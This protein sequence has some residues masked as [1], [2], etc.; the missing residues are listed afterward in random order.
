LA[1]RIGFYPKAHRFSIYVVVKLLKIANVHGET[2]WTWLE[3]YTN[4]LIAACLEQISPL[5]CNA[6][7]NKDIIVQLD[8]ETTMYL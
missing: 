1:I 8:L 2:T 5:S 3:D 4:R 6:E 7:M